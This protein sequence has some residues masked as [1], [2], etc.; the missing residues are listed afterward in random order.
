[1]LRKVGNP[2]AHKRA[3]TFV[4]SLVDSET[5][6]HSLIVD[7]TQGSTFFIYRQR[8][9]VDKLTNLDPTKGSSL[10]D[11]HRLNG[12]KAIIKN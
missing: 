2:P 4:P 7:P 8:A 11:V 3:L 1:M 12:Q 9:I 6:V 5:E 10:V